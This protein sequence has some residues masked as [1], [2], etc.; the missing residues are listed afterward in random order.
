[1]QNRNG[2]LSFDAYIGDTDFNKTIQN[3][4]RRIESLTSTANKESRKM[5]S[6]FSN[7]GRA[8]AGG[9]AAIGLAQ[10][11]QQIIRVRGEFQQLEIAFE[12]MLQSK[13]KADKLMADVTRF[14]A[15]TPY[16]LKDTAAATKQL[17]AYGEQ[18]DTV[19]STLTK[20]GDIASGIGAPLGDI[21]YLYGT[22]MTQG[23]LYTQDLNQFTGRGIPMIKELAK[24]MGDAEKDVKGLVEAGKIGFPEVQKVIENLTKQGSMFGGL[25][26]AQSK[27]LPGLIAQLGDAFDAAFNDI[28]KSQQ[29]IIAEAIKGTI[30][31]VENYQ[32]VI[33]VITVLVATYGTYRAALALTAALQTRSVLITEIQAFLSLARS[34]KSAAEAQALFNLVVKANPYVI[35]ATALAAL[36]S[37]FIVFGGK[38]TEA[39]EAQQRMNDAAAESELAISKEAANIELL[40]KQLTDETK[41]REQKE[42]ILKKL[43]ALNPDILSGITLENAATERSTVAIQD[44]IRAK[45]EQIRISTIQ[46]QID[47]NLEKVSKIRSGSA[48]GDYAPGFL[49]TMAAGML[50]SNKRGGGVNTVD[51]MRKNMQ[52]QKDAAVKSI[53]DYNKGLMDQVNNGIEQ[54][55]KSRNKEAANIKEVIKKNVA[56]YNEEIKALKDKQEKATTRSEYDALEKQINAL[57]KRRDAITGGKTTNVK[58]TAQDEKNER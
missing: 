10:L 50:A 19:I 29:G 5:D 58:K 25:M 45:K 39:A 21:A 51:V 16:G 36:V 42:S 41:T 22:T 14:A 47:A 56:N 12:T 9:L 26:E 37:G 23:R 46:A 48:D 49:E 18:A 55:R 1:M 34:I 33:D 32:K 6:I 4:N 2:A 8:A 11:P 31:V 27:S 24:I 7:L 53:L 38:A 57:E 15:L 44:Y 54:R 35:A 30:G 13:G 3:M 52:E 20:L 28:G 17:L 43:I 40:R